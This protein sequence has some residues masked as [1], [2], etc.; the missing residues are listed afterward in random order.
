MTLSQAHRMSLQEGRRR[1]QEK[2][3]LQIKKKIASLLAQ[4]SAEIGLLSYRE[5]FIAGIMLYWA[6]GFKH[7]GE[8]GLGFATSDP[9]MA[10]FYLQWIKKCLGVQENELRLRVTANISHKNRINEIEHYWSN[11]LH[12]SPDQFTKPFYQKSNWKKQYKNFHEYH[13][14]IRIHVSRSLDMLRKMRG[15]LEGVK[16]SIWVQ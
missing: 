1:F 6:E 12:L 5:L 13:G 9:K 15:W 4:G 14:V 10:K 8:S 16:K 11:Y 2:R 7:P 3:S